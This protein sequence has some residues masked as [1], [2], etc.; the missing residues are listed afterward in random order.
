[1][2][3]F[4]RQ[5]L[6]TIPPH[7]P[8]PVTVPGCVDGWFE[9]HGRFG[10]MPM[11]QVLEPAATYAEKGFPVSEV[12]AFYWERGAKKLKK[13]PGFAEVFLPDGKAPAKGERFRNPA[14]AKTLRRLGEEGRDVFYRGEIAETID[15]FMKENKGFL[16]YEDLAAHKSEWVDPVSTNYRG[17]D[18]CI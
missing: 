7:G 11:K 10:S 17:Y 9:L 1:M 4:Q 18:L 2:A 3:E 15:A 5:K 6:T 13:Q 12:I 14:L 16:S 8:L